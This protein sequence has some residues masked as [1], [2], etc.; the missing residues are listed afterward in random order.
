MKTGTLKCVRLGSWVCCETPAPRV[1]RLDC[2]YLFCCDGKRVGRVRPNLFHVTRCV[3]KPRCMCVLRTSVLHPQ[4]RASHANGRTAA[5]IAHA[6]HWASW[7]NALHDPS[8]SLPDRPFLHTSAGEWTSGWL[9]GR[10]LS[11]DH[12]GPSVRHLQRPRA[13]QGFFHDLAR[14]VAQ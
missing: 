6:A 7:G 9:C 8:A 3:P 1:P 10:V 14:H 4:K 5:R 13:I 12:R 2:P 11:D